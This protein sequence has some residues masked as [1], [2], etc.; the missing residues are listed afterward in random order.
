MASTVLSNPVSLSQTVFVISECP[1]ACEGI[2]K[3]L[4]EGGGRRGGVVE[5]ARDQLAVW[6]EGAFKQ[7][8]DHA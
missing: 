2:V 5:R 8:E 7:S 1:L 6:Q 4:D 3:T